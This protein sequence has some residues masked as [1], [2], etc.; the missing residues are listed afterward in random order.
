MMKIKD[1]YAGSKKPVYSFEFFPPKTDEGLKKLMNTVQDMKILNPGFISVTYGA[2]GST[3]ERTMDIC[4]DIQSNFSIV[5]A[6]H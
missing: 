5:S 6:C 1:I 4:Q 2:G 3:K